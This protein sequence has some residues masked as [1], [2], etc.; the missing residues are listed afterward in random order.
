MK[1]LRGLLILSLLLALMPGRP[2][3]AQPPAKGADIDVDA[4][5]D[6]ERLNRELWEALKKT[7]YAE[8]QAH[9]A[10]VRQTQGAFDLVVPL[11]NG[12]KLAPAGSS[13]EVGRFPYEA[14]AYAGAVVVLNTGYYSG[15]E[16]P[17]VSVVDPVAGTVV[18]ILHFEALFPSAQVGQDGDLYISGGISQKVYR[19]NRQWET[20]RTYTVNGYAGPLVPLDATHLVVASLVTGDT[21][22]DFQ[23]GKYKAGRLAILNTATGAIERE[24]PTGY[25][26]YALQLAGDKL[27]VAL[28]GEG[29]IQVCDKQLQSLHTITVGRSPEAMAL[30]GDRLYVVN[31]NSDSIS[32]LDTKQ[33]KV[34][35][36]WNLSANRTKYGGAPTSCA[37]GGDRLYVTLANTNAVA[38]LDKHSGKSLGLLPTGWYPTKVL[39]DGDRLLTLSAKGIR[40][41]RPNP[42]GPNPAPAPKNGPDYVLTLLKGSLEIIPIAD[43]AK[44]DQ[45]KT[46]TQVVEM[47]APQLLGPARKNTPIRHIF[48][49]VRENRTY[50]QVLG[51]LPLANGDPFL[52]LFGRDITPNGHRLAE[53][54]VTLDNYFADGEI[55]V[56]GHSFTTSGYASPF[57]E[58]IGNATYSG[59]YRSYPFGTV[60]AVTSPAYLWDALDAKHVDYRIYGENYY[61]YT[62]GYALIQDAFGPDSD[63]AKKFYAQMMALASQTDR[64]NI[65]YQF[66]QP[67]YGQAN[68][69]K[70]ARALLEKP[71]FLQ[72]FSSFLCGDQSLATALNEKPELKERFA[73]YLARYPFNYRSWDLAT[74]DLDRFTA[75]KAD[76]AEQVKRGRVAQLQYIWLP[77]DHT[78]GASTTPLPPD[79][80]V[81]QNDAALGRIIETIAQSPIWKD[82]LILVTEDDAQN[83]PD[84][85]DA[86]R[87]VAL[88][89]GPWVK[90]HAV[91]SDRYDQLSLLRTIEVLLGL[92]PLNREDALAV[93]MF[94]IFADAPDLRP[95][96]QPAASAHLSEADRQRFQKTAIP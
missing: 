91:V 18:Q 92:S 74:S 29:K 28:Q 47:C 9:I 70:E 60:P 69:P 95:F 8:A 16:Q 80:L 45:L 49:I 86:T 50:D 96:T 48:Y 12:W 36:T 51:D 73:E 94:G 10:S 37:V 23:S 41:R 63:I 31:A 44:Q 77:N 6:E 66:A 84:H 93:P 25:F 42:K 58:W 62:R 32:V 7:P 3:M 5:G 38:V 65:F 14:V 82:S 26:P 35:A 78:A 67:Y 61:L 79:Q 43:T 52:T 4:P 75:W 22:A 13:V 1:W 15:Q 81:A 64:G 88:A 2:A 56:L 68:T 89:V 34:L 90:R 87:T 39:V 40:S 72:A 46:W 21:P 55:S 53:E 11:P 76:F 85:V 33:D 59:R 27:Y 71:E 20:V 30:D 83:G 19:V 24:A 54:F 57:L 17:E